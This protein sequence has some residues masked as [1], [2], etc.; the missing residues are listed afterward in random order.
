MRC[1]PRNEAEI[2]VRAGFRCERRSQ[3]LAPDS[4]EETDDACAHDRKTEP[5]VGVAGSLNHSLF[6][7]H[8]K[9]CSHPVL[10]S[11]PLE[12]SLCGFNS[13]RTVTS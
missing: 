4:K 12:L 13:E 8:R 5:Q 9:P 10:T 2:S 1:Y 11:S 7:T 6:V 3:V